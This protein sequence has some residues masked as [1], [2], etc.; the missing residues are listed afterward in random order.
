[1][2]ERDFR[3]QLGELAGIDVDLHD[4]DFLLTWQHSDRTIHAIL[5]LAT[6][7][8]AMARSNLA[9]RV[10]DNG[11]GV[12]IF[13]D[14]STR[15]RNA[16][17]AGMTQLGGHAHF[18][19]ADATQISHGETPED[20][21][22]I[23]AAM[24]HGICI[25]HDL[26][27]NEGNNIRIYKVELAG[28]TDVSGLNSLVGQSYTPVSKQLLFT[29]P[30]TLQGGQFA[31]DNIEAVTFWPNFPDGSRSILLFSD[32]NFSTGQATQVVL[33]KAVPEPLSAAICSIF[34]LCAVAV[35]RRP[36]GDR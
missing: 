25:R 4:R 3:T 14:K 24:G 31:P 22:R 34:G 13:R 11:L 26:V 7:L 29:L 15:T 30:S 8:E 6:I 32:N 10:F 28:A 21:G 1:M 12:A 20:T 16:F 35:F 19:D 17:E 5:G 36:R 18:L 2:S 23:L 33:L 9:T 27:L